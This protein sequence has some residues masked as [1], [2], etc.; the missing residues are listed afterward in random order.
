MAALAEALRDRLPAGGSVRS[1]RVLDVGAIRE[2]GERMT[3]NPLYPE[4]LD[5]IGEYRKVHNAVPDRTRTDG[6]F[7]A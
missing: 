4:F 6:A 1:P 2:I 3:S 5:A 7:P